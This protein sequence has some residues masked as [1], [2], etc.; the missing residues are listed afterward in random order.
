MIV[1]GYVANDASPTSHDR[2]VQFAALMGTL[3]RTGV[4]VTKAASYASLTELLRSRAIDVAWLP[5]IPF[6]ALHRSA[7]VE[8][9]VSSH[10]SGDFLFFSV[11]VVHA[12][13]HYASP[14]ELGGARAVWVD[15]HSA[16]G[17]VLP[18][19]ALAAVGTDPATAFVS[20]RF[21]RSHHAVVRAVASGD[22]DV[23]ATYAGIDASG[24]VVRGAW[25][26]PSDLAS[27]VR[28]VATFG[29]IPADVI[30]A[31]SG[32][33]GSLRKRLTRALV[34]VSTDNSSGP[35]VRDVFG[36]DAFRRWTPR[37]YEEMRKATMLASS[38]GLLAGLE[39]IP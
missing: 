17:Y 16:S 20:E 36:V 7:L 34:V 24:T 2:V 5:P 38:K 11:L 12:R 4:A 3:A 8:P 35:L 19:I 14:R 1:F 37:G 25:L 33:D 39:K 30:A 23:G 9:L 31:R 26:E 29:S 27:S 32:L 15:P 6:I 13:S 28:V 10:R 21:L 18:R 22:A